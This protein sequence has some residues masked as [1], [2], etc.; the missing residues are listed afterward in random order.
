MNTP[1]TKPKACFEKEVG[2][3]AGPECAKF[4]PHGGERIKGKTSSR[5]ILERGIFAQ[6]FCI[7]KLFTHLAFTQCS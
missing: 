1:P 4:H 3:G 5:L 6:I 2:V 7:Y